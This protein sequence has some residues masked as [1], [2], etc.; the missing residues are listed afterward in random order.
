M[1][2]I[3]EEKKQKQ[4]LKQIKVDGTS[5]LS[6]LVAIFAIVSLV[7][8]GVSGGLNTSYALPAVTTVPTDFQAQ[9]DVLWY[10]NGSQLREVDL[11]FGK[12]DGNTFPVYCLQQPVDFAAAGTT[13]SKGSDITDGGLI[14][15]LANLYP[16]AES[17][18]MVAA[19][20]A[21]QPSSADSDKAYQWVSQAVIW[22]Y[23]ANSSQTDFVNDIK[24]ADGVLNGRPSTNPVPDETYVFKM[25]SGAKIFDSFKFN[26]KTA[27]ELLTK[28]KSITTGPATLTSNKSSAKTSTTKDNKYT[29]YGPITVSGSVPD[30]SIGTYKGYT[31]NLT[32]NVPKGTKITDEEGKEIPSGTS[33]N[34]S[35]KFYVT[36]PVDSVK[37]A[38]DINMGIT[39]NFD[40][41]TGYY[42]TT[43]DNKQEVTT[44]KYITYAK[45]TNE[46]FTISPAPDTGMSASQTIYFIGLV[47]LLCGVG[48]IYANAKPSAQQQQAQQEQ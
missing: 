38:T 19:S 46:K 8:F 2:K 45:N 11:H 47:V 27:N 22:V 20:F 26:G 3:Y 35:S 37:E 36:I 44:V 28:A 33:L 30:A 34:D 10:A 6:F 18:S 42:Y 9:E 14:Y 12:K 7:S 41:Y 16:N 1:E 17:K 13:Y 39:G 21:K 40:K 15:L 23:L 32:G 4:S 24:N 31:V 25:N 43:T 5:A 29:V 48:I